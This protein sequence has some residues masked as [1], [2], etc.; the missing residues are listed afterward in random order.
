MNRFLLHIHCFLLTGLLLLCGASYGAAPFIRSLGSNN[1]HVGDS[2]LIRGRNLTPDLV[3]LQNG[4]PSDHVF[5]FSDTLVTYRI[6]PGSSTGL[7]EIRNSQG[8]ATSATAVTILPPTQGVKWQWAKTLAT[9]LTTISTQTDINSK[10][11]YTLYTLQGSA[12]FGSTTLTADTLSLVLTLQNL[13]GSYRWASKIAG[14][15]VVSGASFTVE[16][17]GQVVLALPAAG[18]VVLADT[19][20]A[21]SS[22]AGYTLLSYTAQ[23]Q[24]AWVKRYPSSSTFYGVSACNQRIYTCLTSGRTFQVN[25]FDQAGNLIHTYS[26]ARGNT[27]GTSVMAFA[28]MRSGFSLV[29]SASGGHGYYADT[30]YTPVFVHDTLAVPGAGAPVL[31]PVPLSPINDPFDVPPYFNYFF[32]NSYLRVEADLS[33]NTRR[34]EQVGQQHIQFNGIYDDINYSYTLNRKGYLVSRM[35]YPV[36][37][38]I[39][40]SRWT[41]YDSSMNNL[42]TY[43]LDGYYAF[44]PNTKQCYLAEDGRFYGA[45][46]VQATPYQALTPVYVGGFTADQTG[47]YIFSFK[48]GIGVESMVCLAGYTGEDIATVTGLGE[49]GFLITGRLQGNESIPLD[50]TVTA[51]PAPAAGAA[52]Q[53]RYGASS[54]VVFPSISRFSPASGQAGT[55]VRIVGANFTG[56]QHVYFYGKTAGFT[57]V[58]DSVISAVAPAGVQTGR[59]SVENAFG[60]GTSTG[61]FQVLIPPTV[62]SFFPGDGIAGDR[63]RIRGRFPG[64]VQS[65][66]FGSVTAGSYSASGDSVISAVVPAGASSAQIWVQ[67]DMGLG[68]SQ[69]YFMITAPLTK[70]SRFSPQQ[71][72]VGD[73]VTLQGLRFSGTVAVR[74]NGALAGFRVVS[75]TLIRCRVPLSGA[76]TG[77]IQVQGSKNTVYSSMPFTLVGGVPQLISFA[78]TAGAVGDK[79]RIRGRNLSAVQTVYFGTVQATMMSVSGDS[80]V[81]VLVPPG[82]VSS[83]IRLTAPGGSTESRS[84]YTLVPDAFTVVAQISP[85]TGPVGTPVTVKGRRFTGLKSVKIGGIPMG[86]TLLSDSELVAT[87]P[88]TASTNTIAVQGLKNTSPSILAFQVTSPGARVGVESLTVADMLVYPN[89]ARSQFTVRLSEAETGPY[90]ILIQGMD[91]RMVYS[92]TLEGEVLQTGAGLQPGLAPGLYRVGLVREGRTIGQTRL[93]IGQ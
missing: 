70:L 25:T 60:A 44:W 31:Y 87:V 52:Y 71:G 48:P 68:R 89:P 28:A 11:I 86:Y 26:P 49:N 58:S 76:T 63:V 35:D 51:G 72:S 57:V 80:L 91:G 4:T 39:R 47:T 12:T 78:P 40:T 21:A 93:V 14:T 22:S 23:G 42:Y 69:A 24:R 85:A 61:S 74:F 30:N 6:A 83:R 62:T 36:G 53:A 15:G 82:A 20:V 29:L 1:A 59:I 17:S 43:G 56:V 3:V 7:V 54:A 77:P 2:L 41:E 38:F 5:Y 32:P 45:V 37:S 34:V 55:S 73:S 18:R 27:A 84:Y 66:R 79:V 88:P 65:V 90:T 81:S 75:D 50:S 19:T 16:E 13:D 8:S 9:G 64:M 10:W 92:R 46:I 67:T 33:G